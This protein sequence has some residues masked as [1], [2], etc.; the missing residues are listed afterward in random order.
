MAKAVRVTGTGTSDTDRKN[1]EE[2][3]EYGNVWFAGEVRFGP[4]RQ[5]ITSAGGSAGELI[6]ISD[7]DD[8]CGSSV[9]AL[10]SDDVILISTSD[11][12]AIC[13]A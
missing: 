11:I 6:T 4:D 7:I 3:D 12:D 8:I 10:T 1:I 13:N 9:G 5:L 2:L